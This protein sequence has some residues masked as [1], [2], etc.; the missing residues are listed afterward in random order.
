[1]TGRIVTASSIFGFSNLRRYH[2]LLLLFQKI[3][4]DHFGQF[5]KLGLWGIMVS[6][7][8]GLDGGEEEVERRKGHSRQAAATRENRVGRAFLFDYP[9]DP[10][11]RSEVVNGLPR[12]AISEGSRAIRAIVL[13][14]WWLVA[15]AGGEV[16]ARKLPRRIFVWMILIM[17]LTTSIYAVPPDQPDQSDNRWE[18]PELPD[19]EHLETP[20]GET[21]R[22]P[23]ETAAQYA[24]IDPAQTTNHG[25]LTETPLTRDYINAVDFWEL[26]F[27]VPGFGHHLFFCWKKSQ[28]PLI[29]EWFRACR[30]G[31]MMADIEGVQVGNWQTAS[32]ETQA[33]I[34]R[35]RQIWEREHPGRIWTPPEDAV[36]RRASHAVKMYGGVS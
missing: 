1:M 13:W 21:V 12:V 18:P 6:E 28:G 34:R 36:E 7:F 8:R 16:L 23:T 17:I 31:T 27:H 10:D 22:L 9:E 14:L 24:E 19:D 15:V 25:G 2:Q 20:P 11:G 4:V 3:I 33:N 26:G 32:E 35:E 30:S 5:S 29:V